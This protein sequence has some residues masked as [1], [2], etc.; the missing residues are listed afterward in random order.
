MVFVF[1]EGYSSGAPSYT[2]VAWTLTMVRAH[3]ARESLSSVPYTFR[4]YWAPRRV[5]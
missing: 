4:K 3:L 2:T 1:L 5:V